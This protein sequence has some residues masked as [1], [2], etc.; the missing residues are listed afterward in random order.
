[1]AA[2]DGNRILHFNI[3]CKHLNFPLNRGSCMFEVTNIRGHMHVVQYFLG[4]GHVHLVGPETGE[5]TPAH[6]SRVLP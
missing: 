4:P 6:H 3:S 1:M 5:A 2:H